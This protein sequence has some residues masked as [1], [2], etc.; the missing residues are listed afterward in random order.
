MSCE[1]ESGQKTDI[2]DRLAKWTKKQ[3]NKIGPKKMN[4]LKTLPF[5][6]ENIG[7]SWVLRENPEHIVKNIV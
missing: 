1:C 4:C 6:V 7:K 3:Q 2:S 5:S